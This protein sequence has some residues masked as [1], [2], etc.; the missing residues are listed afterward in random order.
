MTV[1]R[2]YDV[3]PRRYAL[4]SSAPGAR[5]LYVRL[6]ERLRP[7]ARVLDVGCGD[8]RLRAESPQVVGLD[9]SMTMLRAHPAPRVLGEAT[10][11]PFREGSFD[12]VT[13]V[14]MLY[15]LPEPLLA[16]REARRVLRPGGL[17][18]AVTRSRADS[19]E[20]AAVW[21]P[22]ATTFDAEEAPALVAEVFGRVEVETWDA[23]LITLRDREAV[24]DY[25]VGRFV[26]PADAEERASR[27]RTPVT[28]TKRGAYVY[29]S[30]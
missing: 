23:P 3:N 22:S 26:D 10:A 13:A 6:A 25:L 4:G 21:R 9:G 8:G 27:V 12:A 11:L 18:V 5:G 19:P 24:R 20:L 14:N 30:S 29:G 2:D 28:L 15:H 7:F 1:P 16:V 17:F